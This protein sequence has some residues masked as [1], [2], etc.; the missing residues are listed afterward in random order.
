MSRATPRHPRPRGA[1]AEDAT[2]R[3]RAEQRQAATYR[4]AE[5]VTVTRGL[6]EL[7]KTIHEIVSELMPA[8]G[9]DLINTDDLAGAR[10]FFDLQHQG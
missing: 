8:D 3:R 9:V 1:A 5:A 6:E 7:L 2:E 10:K 4:I